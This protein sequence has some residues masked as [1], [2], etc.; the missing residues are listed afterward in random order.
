M[1]VVRYLIDN[2]S[3]IACG[4]RFGGTAL[5]DAVRHNFEVRNAKLVQTMLREA[6]ADLTATVTDYTAKMNEYADKGDIERIRLLAENGVDVG[7]GDYDGRTPL[8]L[9]ACSGQTSVLEFLLKQQS[10]VLNAVDRFGGT[11][12]ADAL[13]HDNRGAAA[14]LEQAGSL[15]PDDPKLGDVAAKIKSER[16]KAEKV[17]CAPK[18]THMLENSQE[19][20]ALRI[21]ATDLIGKIQERQAVLEP[22]LKRLAWAIKGVCARLIQSNGH[23]PFNDARFVQVE[24][25]KP[26]LSSKSTMTND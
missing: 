9:A 20:S 21:V 10:V 6:G 14:L 19:S 4:D 15:H 11:P 3:D 7:R 12:Y 23:I 1:T 24:I 16:L 13:R 18:I 8:H 17:Y 2:G 22:I 25:L 26:Q 5:E